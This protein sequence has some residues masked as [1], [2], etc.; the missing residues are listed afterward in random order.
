MKHPLWIG[1]A[2]LTL[3]GCTAPVLQV[4]IGQAALVYADAKTAY[5]VLSMQVRQACATGKFKPDVCTSLDAQD[6]IVKVMDADVRKGIMEAKGQV[7]WEKVM[8]ILQVIAGI[9]VKVGGL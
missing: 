9:A 3:T 4:P 2:L 1:V 7:D 6:Q 8:A 5:T